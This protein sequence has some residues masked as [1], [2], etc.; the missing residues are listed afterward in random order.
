VVGRDLEDPA[1]SFDE[2]RF[3]AELLLNLFRQTGGA[4][5]VVSDRAVLNRNVREHT[6]LLSTP[7][8]RTGGFSDSSR[9]E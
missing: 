6:R 8:Y 1:G 7:D 9:E 5:E 2:L 3:D 4:R